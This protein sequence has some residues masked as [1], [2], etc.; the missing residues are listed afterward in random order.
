VRRIAIEL[1]ILVIAIAAAGYA[2][3]TRMQLGDLQKE[4]V[5]LKEKLAASDAQKQ[6]VQQRM[7]E[8]L[9]K[10]RQLQAAQAALDNGSIL[11]DLES[12]IAKTSA[13]PTEQQLALGGLRMVVKGTGDPGTLNA[14]QKALELVEWSKH[15]KMMCAAQIGIAA[16]GK[17]IAVLDEC[18]RKPAAPDKPAPPKSAG[19][20]AA[21]VA[22]PSAAAPVAAAPVAA[23]PAAQPAATV[24]AGAVPAGA[25]PAGAVPAAPAQRRN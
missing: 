3:M 22:P 13:S 15:L 14:F 4:A 2:A 10:E 6:S 23:P 25:V 18:T 11:A 21:P 17:Q 1:V 16:S 24:P 9:L 19:Q 8:L 12:A 5:S 20:T 7:P